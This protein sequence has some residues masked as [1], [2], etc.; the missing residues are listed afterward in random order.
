MYL[1]NW[2]CN[3]VIPNLVLIQDNNRVSQLYHNLARLIYNIIKYIIFYR[4]NCQEGQDNIHL[5]KRSNVPES[6]RESWNAFTNEIM[7]KNYLQI[8]DKV[9]E[10]E[11]ETTQCCCISK[12]AIPYRL[13]WLEL[14]GL[15]G[16]ILSWQSREFQMVKL[17]FSCDWL[18]GNRFF[19]L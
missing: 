6:Y 19:F 17:L 16:T 3:N 13:L 9:I 14:F 18:C 8:F 2:F 12:L 10:D 4:R 11:P 1:I 7:T 5:S 15:A